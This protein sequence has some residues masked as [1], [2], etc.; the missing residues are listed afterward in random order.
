[1]SSS[2]FA[3]LTAVLDAVPEIS[4]ITLDVANGYSEVSDFF[5]P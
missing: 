3:N 4:W 1:V 2:D 5:H